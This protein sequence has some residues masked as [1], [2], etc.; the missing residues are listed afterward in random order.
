MFFDTIQTVKS[1]FFIIIIFYVSVT[2]ILSLSLS[3]SPSFFSFSSVSLSHAHF[4]SLCHLFS[5]SLTHKFMIIFTV[6]QS[7][8]RYTYNLNIT[9]TSQTLISHR[10]DHFTQTHQQFTKTAYKTQTHNYS[11]HSTKT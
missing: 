7:T 5:A 9:L 1:S 6:I 11:T 3:F 10:E 4:I 8:P 2:F